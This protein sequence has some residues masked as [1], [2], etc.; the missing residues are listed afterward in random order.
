MKFQDNSC[1]M[2][3]TFLYKMSH[4][5]KSFNMAPVSFLDP[6]VFWLDDLRN[7]V[8]DFRNTLCLRYVKLVF[9]KYLTPDIL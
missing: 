2:L 1:Y 6:Q 3:K 8:Y 5:L 7:T 4:C 9:K